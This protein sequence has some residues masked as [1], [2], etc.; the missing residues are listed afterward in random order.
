MKERRR[1]RGREEAR[2]NFIRLFI[3]KVCVINTKVL[4][5]MVE[6]LTKQ[7]NKVKFIKILP[8]CFS[9]NNKHP[10]FGNFAM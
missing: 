3:D 5:F 10:V 2:E 4:L 1:E 7:G 9:Y 6:I 8:N